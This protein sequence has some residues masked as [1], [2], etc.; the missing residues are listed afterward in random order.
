LETELLVRDNNGSVY[1]VNY[2]WR[3]DNSDADLLSGSLSEDIL[4]TNATGVR[5]QTWY[6]A[7]PSDCQEC[8]NSSV[9]S[10]PSGVNVLGV[11]ARQLNGRLTYPATGVTDNQLRTLNRLGLFNPAFDEAVIGN[12]PQL[13]AM[14]NVSASLQERVRSYLDVNCEQCHQPGGQG[15]TWDARYDTALANQHITNFPAA[16][17]L[18]LDNACIVKAKDVWRSVLLARINTTDPNI[19]MPDFRNLIDTNAVQVLTDWINS[20]PGTPALAPPAIMP[21][22]GSYIASASVALQSPDPGAAIY[23]TLDGSLPTT[24]S[25]LYAG[26][27]TLFSNTTV[28][29][30]AYETNFNNS[31]AAS[32]L[33]LVQPPYFT[34]VNFLA[35]SQIQLGF[36]G[37]MGSNYVLQA[38]TNF[39]TWTPIITNTAAASLFNLVDPDATNFPFRF[40]RVLQQ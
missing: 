38:T 13:S 30:S 36:Y 2:K 20:L 3:P 1:G 22:G 21:D 18:G 19:Q 37:N 4:I 27:F 17:S 5:T 15:I 6:Y 8:H 34:S 16:I 32:A 35:N 33:F 9:A 7:S 26:T 12:Y 24:N 31:V 11:N 23:Y 40:Y 14:T 39:S 25:L 29:A 10:S 28:S